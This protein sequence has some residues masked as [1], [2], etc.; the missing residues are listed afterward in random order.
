MPNPPQVLATVYEVTSM[1]A[2]DT[3]QLYIRVEIQMGSTALSGAT[4]TQILGFVKNYLQSLTTDPIHACRIQTVR[5]D[6]L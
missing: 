6:G 5:V 1:G 2:K 3:D 4:E